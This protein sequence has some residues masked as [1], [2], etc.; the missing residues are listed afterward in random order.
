VRT[1]LLVLTLTPVLCLADAGVLDYV[2]PVLGTP[3]IATG[4]EYVTGVL[5]ER[6]WTQ[7]EADEERVTAIYV[8]DGRDER[9]TFT[10]T[11]APPVPYEVHLDIVTVE[12]TRVPWLEI[13][14]A[15]ERV[16]AEF[17]RLV[18]AFCYLVGPG[19]TEKN[20]EK[21]SHTWPDRDSSR[22]ELI[23]EPIWDTR[24]VASVRLVPLRM[25]EG[26]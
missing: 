19:V 22:I 24:L 17:D 15:R 1:T 20:E 4:V 2:E 10:F 26:D 7:I 21:W 8:G 23:L 9:L 12:Y 18:E 25:R 14:G 11:P 5:K 3:V 16:K 6:G 13:E